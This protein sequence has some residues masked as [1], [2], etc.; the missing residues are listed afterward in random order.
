MTVLDRTMSNPWLFD[1]ERLN[2][3]PSHL[4]GISKTQEGNFRIDGAKFI[5]S[6]GAEFG[7]HYCT[8]ATATVFFHRFYMFYSFKLFPVYPTAATCL[9][10]A[11]KAEE[12]PKKSN[13]IVK[14]VKLQLEDAYVAQFGA[15]PKEEILTLERILLQ[16]LRFDLEVE[17]AYGYLIK[18]VKNIKVQSQTLSGEDAHKSLLQS[19]WTFINDSCCTTV[20]L[21]YEPEIVAIAM[22][23]LACKT[24]GFEIIDWENR[25]PGIHK[26]WW[27]V[28][29]A[30]L[31]VETLE[32]I[33]HQ[34]LDVYQ[35]SSMPKRVVEPNSASVA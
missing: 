32:S 25:R 31:E 7:L 15:D 33:C 13:D 2:H 20:C 11:G 4:D 27:D 17:H 1:A 14:F 8:V 29:V 26:N 3:T 19:A 22:L 12:T 9:F 23:L 10:L 5:K 30:N 35:Y 24:G 16:T 28:Y 18:Y 21:Q 34:V 6:L